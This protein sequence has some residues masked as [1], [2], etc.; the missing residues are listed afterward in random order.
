MIDSTLEVANYVQRFNN[1]QY[2]ITKY[3][4]AF[5]AKNSITKKDAEATMTLALM[6]LPNYFLMQVPECLL[7]KVKS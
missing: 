1:F 5:F 2:K 4:K 7:C 6:V 3:G